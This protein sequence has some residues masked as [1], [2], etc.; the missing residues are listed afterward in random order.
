MSLRWKIVLIGLLILPAAAFSQNP[1]RLKTG[2]KGVLCLDCHVTVQEQ[3]K[4]PFVHTPVKAGDCSDCHN[5]HA[6]SHG[7]L[8]DSDASTICSTCHSD[9][10]PEEAVSI[11][12]AVLEGNCATCHDPHA[13]QNPKVLVAGGN[14]LCYSCHEEIAATVEQSEFGHAPVRQNCLTCHDPHAS[15]KAGFLLKQDMEALCKSCHNTTQASFSQQHMGYPVADS[16][17]SSCHDPHGSNNGG[18]LL[19]EVH[20]PLTNKM[21]NQCHLEAS[22]PNA[23]ELKATGVQLCRGCHSDVLNAAFNKNRL[24]WPVAD[25]TACLNCHNPHA[26]NET[27]LL[28]APGKELCANCHQDS[29]ARLGEDASRH[30]PV[31]DGECSAC[32]AP[33]AADNVFLSD[34]ESVDDLCGSCHDWRQHSSHP[35]GDEIVDQRNMNLTLDCLSCHRSHGSPFKALSHLDPAGDLCVSC[36]QQVAR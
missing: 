19:A 36:H 8:L 33:H 6:A 35:L 32:H 15:T 12:Q 4:L 28:I 5:P 30:Q 29:T 20:A 10:V 26:S 3:I 1:Y 31:E 14:Q 22:S 13:S 9:F 25:E 16:R 11:H 21:C 2:A 24:H 18:L 27:G 7:Q 34:Y 23:L 17:C